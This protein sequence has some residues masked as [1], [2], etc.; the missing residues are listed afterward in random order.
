MF[1]VTL[2]VMYPGIGSLLNG[3]HKTLEE[4]LAAVVANVESDC[5]SEDDDETYRF[6]DKTDI[7]SVNGSSGGSEWKNNQQLSVFSSAA[8][9]YFQTREFQGLTAEVP[10]GHDTELHNGTFGVASEY[11]LL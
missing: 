6:G 3:S 2:I 4:A 10:Q 1:S 7:I 11:R 8:V 9:E 5:D